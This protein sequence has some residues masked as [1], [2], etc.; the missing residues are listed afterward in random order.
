MNAESNAVLAEPEALQRL[1]AAG[2]EVLGGTPDR[3]AAFLRSEIAAH[4]ELVR[5]AGIRID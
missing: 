2:L 1:Q 5:R 3:L 4:A